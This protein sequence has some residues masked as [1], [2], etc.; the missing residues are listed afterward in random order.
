MLNLLLS[1]SRK[2]RIWID[3][4][5]AGVLLEPS[6]HIVRRFTANRT[7]LDS[8]KFAVELFIP[9]GARFDYG[10]I[11]A[12]LFPT[13]SNALVTTICYSIVGRLFT[14]SIVGGLD[15]V[16]VGLPLDYADA[17]LEGITG[18]TV[19][20][21]APGGELRVCWAAYGKS[22]SSVFFFRLLGRTL[23]KMMTGAAIQPDEKTMT[24]YFEKLST[25]AQ[26]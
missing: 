10:L 4:L 9:R 3:D 5:P 21:G 2:A 26:R 6:G 7:S 19:E 13:E 11:G 23:L 1:R 17:V 20:G 15:E 8:R 14:D 24:E 25:A 16:K 22:G 12:E 18:E